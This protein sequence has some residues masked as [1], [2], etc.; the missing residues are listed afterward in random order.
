MDK[1]LKKKD[2][3]VAPAIGTAILMEQFLRFYDDYKYIKKPMP[4][5]LE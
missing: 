3:I 2:C 5:Y 1:I 4:Q